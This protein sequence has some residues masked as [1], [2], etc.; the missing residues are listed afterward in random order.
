MMKKML[1]AYYRG[2]YLDDTEILIEVRKEDFGFSSSDAAEDETFSFLFR[3]CVMAANGGGFE[4][5]VYIE[6]MLEKIKSEMYPFEIVFGNED[7]GRGENGKIYLKSTGMLQIY[8]ACSYC[9]SGGTCEGT[10]DKKLIYY[11]EASLGEIYEKYKKSRNKWSDSY[12]ESVLSYLK[13]CYTYSTT[14]TTMAI[15]MYSYE[16]WQEMTTCEWSYG[17][18]TVRMT[19]LIWDTPPVSSQTIEYE[20]IVSEFATPV[21]F[22]VDLMEITGSKEFINA[23]IE[24]VG[25]E[26]YVKLMLYKVGNSEEKVTTETETRKTTIN[27]ENIYKLSV[28]KH[29]KDDAILATEVEDIDLNGW[30][31]ITN[32]ITESMSFEKNEDGKDKGIKY[33]VTLSPSE[34]EKNTLY[35][36][37]ITR[38]ENE[39]MRKVALCV[40]PKTEIGVEFDLYPISGKWEGE[41]EVEKVTTVESG[42]TQY[43]IAVLE[44]NT[45]YATYKA[46]NKVNTVMEIQNLQGTEAAPILKTIYKSGDIPD[47]ELVSKEDEYDAYVSYSDLPE[48]KYENTE[49]NRKIFNLEKPDAEESMELFKNGY[50]ENDCLN[51]QLKKVLVWGEKSFDWLSVNSGNFKIIS[52]KYSA[53][54]RTKKQIVT[55]TEKSL[56]AGMDNGGVLVFYENIYNFLGLLSNDTGKYYS[57]ATFKPQTN[58]ASTGK[59]VEYNDLYGG[60]TKVGKLLENGSEMLYT[61]LESSEITQGFV[62]VMKFIMNE[63]VNNNY[64][65]ETYDFYVFSSG[66]EWKIVD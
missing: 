30:T 60:K 62:D 25:N 11:D 32:G 18:E 12:S 64:M 44:A 5:G 27:G 33:K 55:K 17:S 9:Q 35:L 29:A 1:M 14:S 51:I 37:N 66:N 26:N 40:D 54:N 46:T 8:A 47:S 15:K 31:K 23:F 42:T 38:N 24:T 57:G 43:D 20:A 58:A 4:S 61:L 50:S 36:F 13:K 53:T 16:N 2:L 63:F 45:W 52:M 48:K 3:A 21:E 56:K 19:P 39:N 34:L 49:T 22:M 10:F 65:V 28:Y 59:L 41:G 6:A 7:D